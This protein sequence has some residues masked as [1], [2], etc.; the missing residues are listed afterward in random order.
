MPLPIS[1]VSQQFLGGFIPGANDMSL[2]DIQRALMGIEG[3]PAERTAAK[4]DDRV[5]AHLDAIFKNTDAD[6]TKVAEVTTGT[7][8]AMFRVPTD[9]PDYE[10]LQLKTAGLLVGHGRS[11]SFTQKGR[12]ALRMKWLNSSNK[13]KED[14]RSSEYVHPWRQASQQDGSN[15]RT[16]STGELKKFKDQP[17]KKFSE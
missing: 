3:G 17:L 9:V 8:R 4:Y 14:R 13:H 1:S 11:V 2:S 6:L 15:E 12:E 5:L 10:L 7:P 16:A